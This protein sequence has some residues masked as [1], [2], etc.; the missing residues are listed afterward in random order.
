MQEASTLLFFVSSFLYLV[1]LQTGQR[2]TVLQPLPFSI[3]PVF[4]FS[5]F[6]C[7]ARKLLVRIFE[8]S[9]GMCCWSIFESMLFISCYKCRGGLDNSSKYT[10]NIKNTKRNQRWNAVESNL[11]SF[12]V[13]SLLL[14]IMGTQQTIHSFGLRIH[15]SFRY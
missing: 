9:I 10:W 1:F 12:I 7:A 13:L 15:D 5:S 8:T 4:S 11:S 3:L 2:E 14:S 6:L